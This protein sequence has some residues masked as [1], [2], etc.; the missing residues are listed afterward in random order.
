MVNLSSSDE[1]EDDN[2]VAKNDD[3]DDSDVK[4]LSGDEDILGDV[5]ESA[6]SDEDDPHNSGDHVDDVLNVADPETGR[7][8]INPGHPE[9]DPDVFLSPRIAKV[10]KPHQIGGV[11]FL[12]D[13][14]VESTSQF[15]SSSGFGCILAHAMGLGKTIQM[16]SFIHVFLRYTPAR[17]VLCI[18]PINTIQNWMAEFNMWLPA[19]PDGDAETDADGAP[20]RSENGTDE[21]Y[22]QFGLY[23]LND[24]LKNLDMRGKVSLEY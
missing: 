22:R 8:I 1:G 16:V 4:I 20:I 10:I 5:A 21:Q 11:R 23:V 15:G 17:H 19:Q 3:G 18:V 13:N 24:T 7:V 6:A 9:E 12:Y 14:I 2:I